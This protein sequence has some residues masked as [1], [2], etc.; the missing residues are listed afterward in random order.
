[1][2]RTKLESICCTTAGDERSWR[3]ENAG[4]TAGAPWSRERRQCFGNGTVF[5]QAIA[6]SNERL[7][8]D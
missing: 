3:S 2:V 4:V 1:M 8:T 7:L 5:L 6:T